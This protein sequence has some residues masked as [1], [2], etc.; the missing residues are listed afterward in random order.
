MTK[1]PER[2]LF[3]LLLSLVAC[4]TTE[5]STTPTD[6]GLLAQ[7]RLAVSSTCIT[8]S[9]RGGYTTNVRAI[10]DFEIAD[11]DYGPEGWLRAEVVTRGIRDVVYVRPW[12]L[13]TVCGANDWRGAKP[14]FD[15]PQSYAEAIGQPWS[16]LDIEDG[17]GGWQSRRVTVDWDGYRKAMEGWL[18]YRP[19]GRRGQLQASLPDGEGSCSG[20]YETLSES[21]QNWSI[22]CSN[23]LSA[24]GKTDLLGRGKGAVGVGIDGQGRMVTFTLAGS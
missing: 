5:S 20:I 14:F 15:S 2:I 17:G 10:R 24:S 18:F 13:L 23:G 8:H 19:S 22:A 16:R 3:A 21:E 7:V 12:D 4:Q 11:I 1:R 9:D 6:P